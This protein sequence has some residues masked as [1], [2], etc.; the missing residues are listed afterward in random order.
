MLRST[1]RGVPSSGGYIH[2]ITLAP[3]TRDIA[4]DCK[5]QRTRESAVRL[6]LLKITG[7]LT[8]DTSTICLPKQDLNTDGTDTQADKEKG[9]LTESQSYNYMQ[10]MA[11]KRWDIVSLP[12]MNP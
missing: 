7:G 1:D 11:G 5:G 3:K 4:E 12:G 2:D 10:L 9:K 6:C 8:H